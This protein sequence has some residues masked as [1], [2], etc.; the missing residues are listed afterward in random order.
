MGVCEN[1]C[2]CTEEYTN[3]CDTQPAEHDR[4]RMCGLILMGSGGWMV[5][6]TGGTIAVAEVRYAGARAYV[7]NCTTLETHLAGAE[8][9]CVCEYVRG[10]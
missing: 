10:C 8:R 9:V 6:E 1:V 2:A 7:P 3:L 5:L 4:V